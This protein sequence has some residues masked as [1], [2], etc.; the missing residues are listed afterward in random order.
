MSIYLSWFERQF[1]LCLGFFFVEDVGPNSSCLAGLARFLPPPC[2]TTV[3]RRMLGWVLQGAY[4]SFFPKEGRQNL[5][6]AVPSD[7]GNA[8]TKENLVRALQLF[9]A[10]S[11]ISVTVE[12]STRPLTT[13]QFSLFCPSGVS[14]TSP[15]SHVNSPREIYVCSWVVLFTVV[16][17]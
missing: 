12:V 15:G 17:Q 2:P 10:V 5:I 16:L 6:I 9:Q 4:L 13:H 11:D 8:L 1:L 14:C 3:V 7:G